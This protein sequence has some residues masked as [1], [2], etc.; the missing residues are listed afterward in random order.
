MSASDWIRS[1]PQSFC[2]VISLYATEIYVISLHIEF[3]HRQSFCICVVVDSININSFDYRAIDL[4]TVE[5]RNNKD[6]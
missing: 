3:A 6:I 2:F 5:L 1:P 4:F